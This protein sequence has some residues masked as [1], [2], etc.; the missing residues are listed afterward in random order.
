MGT[1]QSNNKL[2]QKINNKNYIKKGKLYNKI[3]IYLS[4]HLKL[5]IINIKKNNNKTVNNKVYT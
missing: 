5:V 3:Y 4:T 2:S 1:K